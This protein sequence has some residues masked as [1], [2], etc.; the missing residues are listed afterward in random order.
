MIYRSLTQFAYLR[1]RL[2]PLGIITRDTDLVVDAESGGMTP[3]HDHSDKGLVNQPL[4]AEHPQDPGTEN[5]FQWL[6]INIFGQDKKIA[7][8]R[9]QAVGN[10]RMEMGMPSAVITKGLDGHDGAGYAM[11][12]AQDYPKKV[13]EALLDALTEL[14]E[15]FPGILEEH[16][17]NFRHAEHVLAVRNG[18]EDIRLQ[19]RPEL[20]D[21][22][23]MAGWAK[24]AAPATERQQ[25]LVVAV[26]TAHPGKSL[27]QITAIK[28]FANNP[29]NN[30]AEK[31]IGFG[32]AIVVALLEPVK[33]IRQN[34]P[35]RCLLRFPG[36]V[37][38]EAGRKFHKMLRP[39][40]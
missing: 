40:P 29:S 28:I 22:L 16:S 10:Y 3:L 32:V 8:L 37:N 24:P 11:R 14:A 12:L 1:Q 5:L 17:Q 7:A 26:R 21:L 36:P 27:V 19:V 13:E 15:Q 34:L 2:L 23:A 31:A 20:D 25:V 30:R 18:I 6:K 4:F 33:P 35:E 39:K 38:S 9:V